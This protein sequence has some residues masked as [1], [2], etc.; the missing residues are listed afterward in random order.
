MLKIEDPKTLASRKFLLN[1]ANS[2]KGNNI[3]ELPMKK[4]AGFA[5]TSVQNF[6]KKMLEEEL[7]S[8][9]MERKDLT[10][11]TQKSNQ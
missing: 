8:E 11:Q 3:A 5:K 4:T 10:K 1:M 2:R 9:D 6:R 7:A